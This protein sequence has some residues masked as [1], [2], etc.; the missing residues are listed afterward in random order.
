MQLKGCTLLNHK[1]I[2]VL[3]IM[4]S[5]D[6]RRRRSRPILETGVRLLKTVVTAI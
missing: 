3:Q 1:E 6:E 2:K 4:E 5:G